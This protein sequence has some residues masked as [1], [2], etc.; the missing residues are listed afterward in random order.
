VRIFLLLIFLEVAYIYLK[1]I[2]FVY[3]LFFP[4]E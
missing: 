1:L 4:K 2:G 3:Y